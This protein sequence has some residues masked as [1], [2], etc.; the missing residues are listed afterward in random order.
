MVGSILPRVLGPVVTLVEAGNPAPVL[1]IYPQTLPVTGGMVVGTIYAPYPDGTP[2]M[3]VYN[4]QLSTIVATLVGSIASIVGS[5]PANPNPLTPYGI[6][7]A[8]VM[9]TFGT[10][11]F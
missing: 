1:T 2:V 10:I 5:M 11:Q 7:L 9:G 8:A 6:G 3:V 4:N